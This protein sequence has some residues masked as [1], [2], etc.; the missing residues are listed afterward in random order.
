LGRGLAGKNLPAP[1]VDDIGEGQE[2]D[3]VERHAEQKADVGLRAGKAIDQADLPQI[4]GRERVERGKIPDRL[5][6]AVVGA[7]SE[8]DRLVL[9]GALVEVMAEFV[10]RHVESSPLTLKHAFT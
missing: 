7:I 2:R 8:Q 3:L 4:A 1:F 10:M 5:V 9:I 6:E